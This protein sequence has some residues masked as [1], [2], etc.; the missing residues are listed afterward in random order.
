MDAAAET[1]R[2]ARAHRGRTLDRFELPPP[3]NG[4]ATAQ[5]SDRPLRPLQHLFELRAGAFARPAAA[6]LES[7]ERTGVDDS[8]G[9]KAALTDVE[10]SPARGGGRP[11]AHQPRVDV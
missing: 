1:V 6:F 10:L 3:R 8:I 7:D 5:P 4:L 2:H 9:R 11:G